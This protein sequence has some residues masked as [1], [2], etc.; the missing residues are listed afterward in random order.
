MTGLFQ[1]IDA[2]TGDAGFCFRSTLR[3][4]RSLA[5][6]RHDRHLQ[7]LELAELDAWKLNDLGLTPED[8][9][10]KCAKPFWRL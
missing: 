8:V 5:M 3:G 9:R 7:R 1:P 4:L 2:D 10:R 6:R